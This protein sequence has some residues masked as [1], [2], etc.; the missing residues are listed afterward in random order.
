MSGQHDD[1]LSIGSFA[2]LTGLSV[3]A[4]RHYDEVGVLR[5]AHVDPRT[6]YRYYRP[7]QVR[8]AR[9][10]RA[11]RAV[12][13]PI[14]EVRD[15]V[16]ADDE[17]YVRDVLIDHRE[18]LGERLHLLNEQIEAL[19]EYIEKGVR[20]T[21]MVK[22]AR[23]VGIN[24]AVTD[25]QAARRFYEDALGCEFAEDS[26]DDGPVHLNATFGDWGKDN[27]FM[28]ALW[29]N[30]SKDG[31]VDLS[32]LVSDLDATYKQALAAGG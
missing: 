4:L 30:E 17:S 25:L 7:D 3:P 14:D 6:N 26:H 23:I 29:P 5:P 13:L 31:T 9:L 1:L 16:E 27:W 28:I 20:M 8:S 10:I 22:G 21:T 12:E 2:L 19:D 11:L 24:I 15:V 18:R 32:F